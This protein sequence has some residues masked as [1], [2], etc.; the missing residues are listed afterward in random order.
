MYIQQET[1]EGTY[2]RRQVRGHAA[3]NEG[4]IGEGKGPEECVGKLSSV[5]EKDDC[6]KATIP[7]RGRNE[8][9]VCFQ[10][11]RRAPFAPPG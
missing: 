4:T 9:A 11:E 6:M 7:S 1:S 8:R 3:D 10:R 2:N 5:K